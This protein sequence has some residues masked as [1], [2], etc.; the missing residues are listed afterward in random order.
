ML[1]YGAYELVVV[2]DVTLG[3]TD[4]TTQMIP[5]YELQSNNTDNKMLLL[6]ITSKHCI[7]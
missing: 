3:L 1:V 4:S 5:S 2:R 6:T 7:E